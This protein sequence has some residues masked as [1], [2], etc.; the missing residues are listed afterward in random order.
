MSPLAAYQ[1]SKSAA[2][3][4]SQ[5]PEQAEESD[6]Q[7]DGGNQAGFGK[8]H[9]ATAAPPL[10]APKQGC[11]HADS[12]AAK[13]GSTF[14]RSDSCNYEVP[15][16]QLHNYLSQ[17]T[18][19]SHLQQ[20]QIQQDCLVPSSVSALRHCGESQ[21]QGNSRLISGPT[22]LPSRASSPPPAFSAH[23]VRS[24]VMAADIEQQ[25]YR[26]NAAVTPSIQGPQ[27]LSQ[28]ALSEGMVLPP[29]GQLMPGQAIA[30]TSP[31]RAMVPPPPGQLMPGQ[32]AAMTS[33]DGATVPQPRPDVAS[34]FP[35]VPARPAAAVQQAPPGSVVHESGTS[36]ASVFS[37]AAGSVATS[38]AALVRAPS[39]R[40]ESVSESDGATRLASLPA[41]PRPPLPGRGGKTG[42][43][44]RS[45]AKVHTRGLRCAFAS[46]Y[47]PS[48][49]H[50]NVRMLKPVS[51]LLAEQEHMPVET[52]LPSQF[53]FIGYRTSSVAAPVHGA[54]A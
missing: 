41:P 53:S 26:P 5:L 28:R 15:S 50:S 4:A 35:N 43:A 38:T 24:H 34:S 52:L 42:R 29:P 32:G 51:R 3:A 11:Q 48:V 13:S 22:R 19:A 49:A 36:A 37:L 46:T 21:Q 54:D 12:L 9:S 39:S 47:H 18:H 30:M 44:P 17:P 10:P 7:Y 6:V 1:N 27:D 2:T 23:S 31:D 40:P 20:S 8:Q 14:A 33:P 25:L 16:A 45:A